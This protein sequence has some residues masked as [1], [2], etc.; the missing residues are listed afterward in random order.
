MK[1]RLLPFLSAFLA[2][3]LLLPPFLVRA[4]EEAPQTASAAAAVINLETDGVLYEKNIGERIAPA[5]FVKLMTALLSYEYREKNGNVSVTVTEEML[6]GS[7]GTKMDLKV[8]ETLPFDSLLAGLVI[9]NANDAALVLASTVGGNVAAFVEMMNAR[10]A[11][12]GMTKTYYENPTGIDS[13]LGATTLSDTAIL[14][15]AVYRTN[16]FTVLAEQ[17]EVKIPATNKS[18]ERKMTNQNALIPFSYVTDYHLKNV[19]GM[20]AGY[21]GAAGHCLAAVRQKGNCTTLVLISGGVDR[22]EAKNGSDI[23]SYR[24]AKTLLEWAEENFSLRTVVKKGQVIREMPVRLGDGVDH[25]ILTSGEEITLLLPASFAESE[26]LLLVPHPEREVFTAPLLEGDL[27]GTM[28]ILLR[29]EKVAEVPLVAQASVNLSGWLV[30]RDAVGSFFSAGPAKVILILALSAAVLYVVILVG[31]VWLQYLR[32]NRERRE[33]L[34]EMNR[35]ENQRLKLVRL[36]EKEENR[37]RLRRVH[38]AFREGFRV[39]SGDTL[40]PSEAELPPSSA[41]PL[42]KKEGKAVAKL[43]SKYKKENR[44]ER[45]SAARKSPAAGTEK[46]RPLPRY[47]EKR[48]EPNPPRRPR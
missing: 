8:G 26:D 40:E 3:V 14:C 13:T 7:G 28:E 4:E 1:K 31:T 12:L 10:A 44:P 43:P 24:D 48:N 30:L 39:L 22:S 37:A 27:L 45:G 36:K 19:R 6:S 20:T 11:E 17:A 25:I 15:K 41:K 34:A 42:T 35:Q 47:G 46:S 5:S 23:T 9:R 38:G 32:E 2:A 16:S 21:T 18:P 33:A 29:G